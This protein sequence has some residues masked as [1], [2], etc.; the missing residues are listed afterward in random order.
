MMVAVSTG[1]YWVTSSGTVQA[2]ARRDPEAARLTFARPTGIVLGGWPGAM[3]GQT[4]ASCAIFEADLAA[5]RIS[6]EVRAVMYDPEGW[7]HTPLAERQDPVAS[8]HR[9]AMLA[10]ERDLFTIVTPH[11]GLVVVPG[12]MYAPGPGESEEEAYVRSGISAE[13]ARFADLTEVQGQRLQRDP[14]EYRSFVARTAAQARR[15][16]P[17]VLVLSG[18]STYPGY[19]ATVDMLL[20]AWESVRD[21]VDGHYLSLNRR[22]NPDVATRFLS[23][24]SK[25]GEESRAG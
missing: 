15:S 6:A 25:S 17:S 4:W 1:Q 21:V 7:E 3:H 14:A 9:F 2:I 11:P 19:P 16:N 12:T 13:A 24:V 20:A 5:D 10:R 22:R 23:L 8:M 18:L